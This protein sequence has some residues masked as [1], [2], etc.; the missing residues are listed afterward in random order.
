MSLPVAVLAVMLGNAIYDTLW[1]IFS[2][3]DD[4][5]DRGYN[6]REPA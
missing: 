5:D 3:D 1:L 6:E 4:P 2:S